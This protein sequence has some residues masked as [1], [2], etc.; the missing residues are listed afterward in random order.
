MYREIKAL[1][2][3]KES[4]I[5]LGPVQK[6]KPCI[7]KNHKTCVQDTRFVDKGCVYTMHFLYVIPI[8]IPLKWLQVVTT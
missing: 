1:K 4:F 3:F 5:I 7:G 2:I 8:W 6:S